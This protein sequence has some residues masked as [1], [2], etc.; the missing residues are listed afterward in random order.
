MFW[1][2]SMRLV[3]VKR[4]LLG[5][6]AKVFSFFSPENCLTGK[7][8]SGNINTHHIK[9]YKPIMDRAAQNIIK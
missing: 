4:M 2:L 8:Y 9:L 3:I 6:Q 7:I 1:L 5:G